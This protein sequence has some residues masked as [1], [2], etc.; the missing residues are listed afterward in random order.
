[1]PVHAAAER[2]GTLLMDLKKEIIENITKDVTVDANRFS[3]KSPF[4]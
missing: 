4:L 1:M 3:N 2:P